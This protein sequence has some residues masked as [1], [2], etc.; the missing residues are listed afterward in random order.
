MSKEN[1]R[2]DIC[3]APISSIELECSHGMTDKN[4]GTIVY[5]L[6]FRMHKY[7]RFNL[8]F[9]KYFFGEIIISM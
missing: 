4:I 3:N 5:T 8:T 6:F 7:Y 9:G 2:C 1:Q